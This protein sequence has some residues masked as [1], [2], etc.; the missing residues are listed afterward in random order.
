MDIVAQLQRGLHLHQQGHLLEAGKLYQEI[1]AE[2]PDHVDALN[3]MGVVMHAT[4]DLGLAEELL[5]RAINLAPDYFA[6]RANLGNVLQ[7]AGLLFES[8][9]AF[10]KALSLNPQSFETL[11]NLSSVLNDT[12]QFD[13]AFKA[14]NEALSL[15][16]AFP[17][18]LV[19]KG[20]ALLG[21][22]R[23]EEAVL[24]YQDA[25]ELA[26]AS[27]NALFNLGNAYLDLGNYDSAIRLYSESVEVDP[28]NA[29]KQFNLAYALIQENKF[30]E[31]LEHFENAISLKPDYVDAFC[32]YASALQSLGQTNRALTLLQKALYFEPDS[33]DLHWNLSL[34]A[35]QNGDME[36]G[37]AEYEWRWKMPTFAHF[38]REFEQPLWTGEDLRGR[39]IF[40]HTEQGFGDNIQFCRFVPEVADRGGRV[41]LECRP[42][43]V[44]LFFSLRG[45]EKVVPLGSSIPDFDLQIPLMSLPHLFV[46]GFENLPVEIPYL[47]TP[48]D[49]TMDFSIEPG[50]GYKV[51]L[52]WSGSPSR[53]DNHRR[54]LS[55]SDMA[56]LFEVKGINYFSLQLGDSRQQLAL[57]DSSAVIDLANQLHDFCDTAAVIQEL[58][59]IISVD[60]A[61]LHL[62]GALAVPAWG[63]M[64][65]PTGFLWMNERN[66][67]PWYPSMRL[68]RQTEPG[69]WHSVIS[70]V[71]EALLTAVADRI[72]K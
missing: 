61:V 47:R 21:L 26:P 50:P 72:L 24:C 49:Y 33:P 67:S 41:I 40:I 35:L 34:V 12:E 29:E 46:S 7:A 37:W 59:L 9:G 58:D 68:F 44:K 43:L 39:R 27:P 55:F 15:E 56:P 23:S 32:N 60:T 62:A 38:K 66:D 69:N 64:A 63:L 17:E 45:V 51:G 28:H 22:G 42:E 65:Q 4:G 18:A 36:I 13:A 52:V 10:E 5:R 57:S 54:S 31:S 30:S 1:L 14:S 48:E 19:N 71:K 11:N 3:L 53:K 20:N 25:L 6:P 2:E 16:P 8:I 70:E